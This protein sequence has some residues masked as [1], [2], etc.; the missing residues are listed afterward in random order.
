MGW[1]EALGLGSAGGRLGGFQTS[2][3]GLT[4]E[5]VKNANSEAHS[6]LLI[7]LL[8]EWSSDMCVVTALL[9][10]QGEVGERE[11]RM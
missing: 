11:G 9:W 1:R 6:D 3:F 7:Q 2:S 5:H 8:W 4:F 10:G